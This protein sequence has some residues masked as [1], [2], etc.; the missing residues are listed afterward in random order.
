MII[1]NSSS[2]VKPLKLKNSKNNPKQNSIEC[3]CLSSDDEDPKPN[4][5]LI[6][7]NLK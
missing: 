4:S 1:G 2:D 6:L 5:D 3:V 7:P